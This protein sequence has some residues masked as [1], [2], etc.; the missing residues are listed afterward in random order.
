MTAPDITTPSA[1]AAGLSRRGFLGLVGG[2]IAVAGASSAGFAS[3]GAFASPHGA[4]ATG[5]VTRDKLGVQLWSCLA[6]WEADGPRTLELIAQMGYTYVEFAI[7]YGSAAQSDTGSGRLGMD[8]KSLRKALDDAGLWCNGGHGTAPYPYD[9][10]AWKQYVEDNL[11]IGTRNLGANITLPATKNECLKYVDA[12]H[13]GHDVARQMGYKGYLYNHLEAASWQLSDVKGK[14]G[15]ELIL[16]NTTHDV[17]NAELDSD[18]AYQPLGTVEKV[19]HYVRKYPGRFPLYH[20]KDGAPNVPLPDGSWVEGAPAEFGTGV[21]GSP[22]P[23][24]PQGRP[25]A[26]FQDLLTA[27]RETQHWGEVLLIAESD[28]SM[29]TCADYQ[30][31]AFKGLNGLTFPYRRRR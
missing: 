20:M 2:A 7:G 24:D 16:E 19:I 21:F 31:L 22:D 12:V 17:W 3:V 26:G 25:H 6:A 14:Y 15:V 5:K 13:R 30:E 10:K 18:H 23:A 29:A 11:V 9:D 28:Q 1:P 8:P 27:A 4:M